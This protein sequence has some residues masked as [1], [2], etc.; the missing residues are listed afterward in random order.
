MNIINF[1]KE[2]GPMLINIIKYL[3]EIGN[4]IC[5]FLGIKTVIAAESVG[6]PIMNKLG[7][8]F[9]IEDG[10]L[11]TLVG[12]FEIIVLLLVINRLIYSSIRKYEAEK[13]KYGACSVN[14]YNADDYW[15]KFYNNNVKSKVSSNMMN[16]TNDQMLNQIMEEQ[17][18]AHN[19][20]MTDHNMMND[21][22]A[23]NN[24][25]MEQ[26]TEDAMRAITPADFGG[27]V[28]G[29]F[30]NPSDTFAYEAEQS[31][32]YDN[33]NDGFDLDFGGMDDFGGFDDF[34]GI[35]SFGNMDDFGSS[36]D[37]GFDSFDN[38]GCGGF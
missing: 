11:F 26:C 18:R 4:E 8:Y 3:F 2:Y 22:M 30:L 20:M 15:D 1:V 5:R 33:M 23:M 32:F 24:T 21:D 31:M 38:F 16:M 10:A 36:F 7:A 12:M 28:H 29:A 14:T 6:I 35:D 37:N 9:N 27:D 25:S 19:Q 34:G 17:M 13:Y